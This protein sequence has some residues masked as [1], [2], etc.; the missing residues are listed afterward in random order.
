MRILLSAIFV[1]LSLAGSAQEFS[2]EPEDFIKDLDKMMGRSNNRETKELID[3]LEPI[4]LEQLSADDQK[5]IID[6]TKNFTKELRFRSFPDL[7]DYFWA[8]I[9]MHNQGQFSKRFKAWN[10]VIDEMDDDRRNKR[11]LT[12]FIEFSRY[13]FKDNSFY[14]TRTGSVKWFTR[15]GSWTLKYDGKPIIETNEIDL[16]CHSK[17]DSI[18][19]LSTSG[20]YDV[21]EEEWTGKDGKVTWARIGFAPNEVYAE[22]SD[23][24]IDMRHP[25]Y[26]ADS[27]V[28]HNSYYFD[29]PL[30]GKFEDKVFPQPKRS[31]LSYPRFSSYSRRL[32]I[33]GIIKNVDY[34][35]GFSQQGAKFLG[36]GTGNTPARLILNYEA[37]PLMVVSSN[38]FL[39]A[40]NKT[41][42][43]PGEEDEERQGNRQKSR[44]VAG[45]ARITM[46]LDKDS[47]THP[48]LKFT[49]LTDE[50]QARLVRESKGMSSTPY[51]NSFH[52]VEMEFPLMVWNIDDP[53]IKFTAQMSDKQASFTS[54]SYFRERNFD[55]LSGAGTRLPLVEIRSCSKKFDTNTVTLMQMCECMKLPPTQVEPMMLRYTIR[56]YVDYNSDN[57]TIKIFDKVHNHVLNKSKLK[58]YDVLRIISKLP[59]EDSKPNAS[60][61]L[62]NYDLTING[63]NRILLSD[64]HRV[65]IFPDEGRIV[66]KKNR[67]FNFS[68]M[69]S[70]GKAEFFGK[71]FEF[72]YDGFEVKMPIVDSLQLWATSN[73]RDNRGKL[74]EARVRT[75]IQDLRGGLEIDKPGN[76]S[77]L[78]SNPR[79]PVFTSEQESYAYYDQNAVL[80]GAYDRDKFN[81]QLEPFELD[82]LDKFKN[83][84]IRFDGTFSSGDIFPDLEET[85]RLQEDYSLG[86]K[87]ET[88]PEGLQAYGGKGVFR[89]ELQLSNKG[90]K[91]DGTIKYLTSSAKSKGFIFYPDSVNGVTESFNV[92]EQKAPVEYPNVSAD[93][94]YLHWMPYKDKMEVSSIKGRDPISMYAGTAEH[95]GTIKYTPTGMSGSGKNSFSGANLYSENMKFKLLELTAD[96]SDFELQKDM[97]GDVNFSSENLQAKV[98]FQDRKGEFISNTGRSLTKFGATLYQAY[99]DRFTWYMDRDEFEYSAEGQTVAQGAD[100]V[101]VEGAEFVSTHPKQDSLRFFAKAAIYN[102]SDVQIRAKKV[103]NINVA[104]ASIIPGDGKVIVNK[105]AKMETLDSAR[106][107]ANTKTK[108]HTVFN[109]TVD[110]TSRWNYAGNG[111][112]NYKDKNGTT[113]QIHFNTIKANDERQTVAYGKIL[114]KD[115]FTLSPQFG[116]KGDVELEA[117]EKNLLFKGSAII[118]HGCSNLPTQWFAFESRIDPIDINIEIEDEAKNENGN[119]ITNGLILPTD[120]GSV[121]GTYLSS[122][123]SEKDIEV[124]K[125]RGYLVYNEPTKEYRISSF[126]KLNERS[127]PGNYVALNTESC[128]LEGEGKM[129][130]TFE[131]GRVGVEPVGTYTFNTVN[132]NL[133]MHY[134]LKMDFLFDDKLLDILVKEIQEAKDLKPVNIDNQLYTTALRNYVGKEEADE[135]LGR[136]S[137]G[138][139]VKLPEEIESSFFFSDIEMKYD[140]ENDYY[141]TDGNI[142]LGSLGDEMLNKYVKGGIS[143]ENKRRGTDFMIYLDLP[144]HFY[145]LDY[146]ASTGIMQIHT[147]NEEFKT[148][149]NDLKMD[150]RRIKADKEMRKQFVYQ[151]GSRRLKSEAMRKFEKIE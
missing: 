72:S 42:D 121:Y 118:K 1:L 43:Q 22:L 97:F 31:M 92:E 89:D 108:F 51:Y 117:A 80:G 134:L 52:E 143:F 100:A 15:S 132:K 128:L 151:I 14:Q 48:G 139:R 133:N 4:F 114:P 99:L 113:Q 36:T 50:R 76:K 55:M 61:S 75:L 96:T 23:Y 124:V 44:I 35:G 86:F 65:Q 98:N 3:N 119:L 126:Q 123:Y 47:I 5:I 135:L 87:R 101:Q 57:K 125:A 138:K 145:I 69:V 82:S 28:F 40:L 142:G 46:I 58:D 38:N 146:R 49:L 11:D 6:N 112:Y 19:I 106:V 93:S 13:L 83:E 102:A 71:E 111:D 85:L 94:T 26:E 25:E 110:I 130:I 127:L 63:V 122:P 60:L 37:N 78:E 148:T 88:G 137:L 68:G 105:N 79:Y 149:L 9:N 67:D 120:S 70:A 107:I 129:D 84:Q 54:N 144:Q 131:T 39:I 18:K 140:A 32:P 45:D 8:I 2:N 24:K 41:N 91:G 34:D 109:A 73:K 141:V 17:G 77:G 20:V 21:E 136:M 115:E 116:Y 59:K 66:M 147:D 27:V 90:L 95:T 29:N 7:H 53:L 64:S 10:S 56:R 103:E 81:F 33:K 62:L 12:S 104:D 30:Q 74:L 16:I 150:D